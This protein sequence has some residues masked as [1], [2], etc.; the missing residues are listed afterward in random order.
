MRIIA[1]SR[2]GARIFAPRG[3]ETRP[4]ADRVREAAFNLLGPD[5]A[6]GASVLDLF[7]GS[8]ALGFEAASRGASRAVLVER[9]AAALRRN[10]A[11]LP[12]GAGR[13]EV[14]PLDA[15]AA[16]RELERRGERFEIVFADPP[17]GDAFGSEIAAHVAE[18]CFWDL[19]AP[20]VRIG[21]PSHPIPYH[22]DLEAATLPGT[23]EITSAVR[24]L[25]AV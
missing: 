1:G 21:A 9:D 20:V 15:G 23:P 25:S 24:S 10:L 11:R 17:Y 6:D 14:L 5:A 3:L 18:E 2:K 22:K 13:I 12:D 16:V 7:A 4:T 8:G 19:D